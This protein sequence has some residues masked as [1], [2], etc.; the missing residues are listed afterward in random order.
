MV[1]LS[2]GKGN[3]S[4]NRN[5]KFETSDIVKIKIP[6]STGKHRWIVAKAKFGKKYVPLIE[7]LANLSLLP[8]SVGIYLKGEK[9]EIHVNIPLE[10]YVRHLGHNMES[11]KHGGYIAGFDFNPDRVNMVIVDREGNI[12]DI[13][14]KHF[15]EVT[16]PGFPKERAKDIRRKAFAE[17][18]EYA[19]HHGVRDYVAEKLAKPGSKKYSK[20]ANRKISKFALRQY[21]NNLETLI[22]RYNGKLHLM[23]P[24]YSSVDAIPLAKKLGLDRHTASAYLLAIRYLNFINA[25]Q[26]L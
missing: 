17:L 15:H 20:T 5:I 3:E 8:Y 14:S 26:Y 16:S 2:V 22:P 13:R 11:N 10:V 18:V 6:S 23:N 7:K 12:L 21:L 1:R 24:A 25:Y 9:I 19:Y 4:G